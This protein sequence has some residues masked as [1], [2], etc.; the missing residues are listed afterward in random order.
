MLLEKCI[1]TIHVCFSETSPTLY[2]MRPVQLDSG[3]WD[4]F[5]F[6][7][8][9][10]G[11]KASVQYIHLDQLVQSCWEVLLIFLESIMLSYG[12]FTDL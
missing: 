6:L 4:L 9:G 8:V 3:L 5:C 11:E 10:V 12:I 2:R 7:S 1:N